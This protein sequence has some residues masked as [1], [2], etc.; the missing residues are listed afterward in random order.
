[1]DVVRSID[2]PDLEAQASAA[3]KERWPEFIFH[4]PISNAHTPAV[5]RYFP[6]WDVW[7]VDDNRVIAGGWGVPLRWDGT[8]TDLPEG[9][10]GSLVRSVQGHETGELANTFCLMAVAVAAD[11][12][13]KGLAGVVVSELRDRAVAGGFRRVIAPVRPS[14]KH[15]YPLVPMS[16]FATWRRSDGSAFDPWVRTHERLGAKV[17]GVASRS[18]VIQGTIGEWETWTGMA[19]PE[20][21]RYV[22]P[23]A[24]GLV[25]ID[26]E[27]DHG[28][29]VEENLWM[30]HP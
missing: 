30:Q 26:R 19:F 15:R 1:V 29:Y 9:Y 11:A 28:E 5:E 20:S 13:R 2:R 10:D 17:L 14:L 6:D 16:R 24:L 18:M 23:D 27:S 25:E 21:G 22:V 8:V 7:L 12:D 3:F 4:D